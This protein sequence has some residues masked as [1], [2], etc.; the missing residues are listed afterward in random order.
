MYVFKIGI[1]NK[2]FLITINDLMGRNSTV[3]MAGKEK[4]IYMFSAGCNFNNNA[5]LWKTL[6]VTILLYSMLNC[7]FIYINNSLLM[8]NSKIGLHALVSMHD[9]NMRA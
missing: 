4:Q 1:E 7:V 2:P 8:T 6:Q 3:R 9:K 5:S